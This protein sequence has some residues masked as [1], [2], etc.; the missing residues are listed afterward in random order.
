MGNKES[1]YYNT[2]TSVDKASANKLESNTGK[3]MR[4]P[5]TCYKRAPLTSKNAQGQ[6]MIKH[7]KQSTSDFDFIKKNASGI[8]KIPGGSPLK[9]ERVSYLV[10]NKMIASGKLA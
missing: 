1:N 6:K 5:N 8:Q 2:N 9:A 3:Q 4:A 10:K 7:K